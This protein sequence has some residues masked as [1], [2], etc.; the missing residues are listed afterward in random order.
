MD[1]SDIMEEDDDDVLDQLKLITAPLDI[2]KDYLKK[3]ET[4][5]EKITGYSIFFEKIIKISN[6]TT[7]KDPCYVELF[8]FIETNQKDLDTMFGAT[9]DFL[10]DEIKIIY[11]KDEEDHYFTV[12]ADGFSG[13]L[14][15]AL[16]SLLDESDNFLDYGGA[17][18]S[19]KFYELLNST[20]SFED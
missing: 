6:E 14:F 16:Y 20:S 8:T 11:P 4:L 9:M 19:D 17:Y 12:Q 7:K 10:M 5:E 3:C 1:I 13:E 2:L 15:F 18:I